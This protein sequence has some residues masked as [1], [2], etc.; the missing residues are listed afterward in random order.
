MQEFKLLPPKSRGYIVEWIG[1]E[2][3][4]KESLKMKEKIIIRLKMDLENFQ[5]HIKCLMK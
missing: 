1:H 3:E 2:L 5:D 4:K